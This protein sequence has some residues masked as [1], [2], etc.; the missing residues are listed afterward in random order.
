MID[1]AM[2]FAI[3]AMATSLGHKDP[4]NSVKVI[5]D[6]FRGSFLNDETVEAI[7]NRLK[8]LSEEKS[9]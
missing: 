4:L 3:L 7:Y 1:Q 8:Q 6:E 5:Y 9:S 2:R